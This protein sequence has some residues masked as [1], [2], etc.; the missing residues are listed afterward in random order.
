MFSKVTSLPR[1]YSKDKAKID[2]SSAISSI[3]LQTKA[4]IISSA[5]FNE[6]RERIVKIVENVTKYSG[7]VQNGVSSSISIS[8]LMALF[9]ETFL[10]EKEMK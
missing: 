7:K 4:V 10:V 5:D 9:T 2:R 8:R 3:I 6:I 1:R